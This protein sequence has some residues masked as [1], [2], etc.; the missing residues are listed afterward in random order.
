[1]ETQRPVHRT[2]FVVDVE[3]FGNRDRNNRHQA[4][5][6]D[7]LYRTVEEAFREAEIP[8]DADACEDR[9]DGMFVLIPPEVPKSLFVEALPTAL[10]AGLQAYN[11]TR[12]LQEQI[13]LRMA[14][15]AGEVIYDRHGVTGASINLAFRLVD[16]RPLKDALARS[17][18]ALAIIVSS[19]F[20]EEVVQHLAIDDSV[21]YTPVSVVIKETNTTGW[22]CLPDH[23]FPATAVL[24]TL[25]TVSTPVPQSPYKGLRAFER[26]DRDLFFG[27]AKVVRELVG[28][29]AA[30]ALV[31][32]VGASG[33]GK[34]SVVHAGLL[35]R[36]ED[37][38][39][40]GFVTV[41]PRPTLLTALA[42]GLIQLSGTATPIPGTQ[43]EEWR[44]RISER[45]LAYAAEVA[46]GSSGLERLLIV[47]DQ[48]E[49]VLGQDCDVLLQ[50]LANLP[51]DGTLTVV[52]TL[53]EDSFGD[54]FVRHVS[55]GERLRNNA[56][57]L[58]G[59]DRSEVAEAVRNPA[60]LRDVQITDPL[61]DE[62]AE[63]IL[64]HP[65]ALPLLEFS[66]DQMWRTLRPGDRKLSFD[67]YEEIGRV[68]GAL[69]THADRILASMSEADQA[70]VRKVFVN[71][72][73][74]PVRPGVRKVVLRSECA[75][76]EWQVIVRLA[77]ERLLTIRRDDDGNETGEVVHEALLRAW[78]QLRNWLTT[79]EPFRKW[80]QRLR[81][82]MV[83]WVESRESGGF[84]TGT[85]LADSERWVRERAAD[86]KL[87]ELRFVEMSL[88][89]RKQEQQRYQILYH[90]S[91]ARTLSYASEATEDPVLALL[92]AIEVLE[93]SPDAQ[94]D[95]LVRMC[96]SQLKAAEI[97]PAS[98]EHDRWGRDRFGRRLTLAEWSQVPGPDGRWLLCD[99]STGLSIDRHGRA[100]CRVGSVMA[101]PGPVVVGACTPTGVACLG[102]EQGELALW[103]VADRPEK[104]ISRD[105]GVTVT[106]LAI[107][108]TARTVAV[109]C[110]TDDEEREF[111]LV[112]RGD[113]L[114][115][116]G[117]IPRQ[118]YIWDV[119]MSD[120]RLVAALSYD[121]RILIWDLVAE[122]LVCES[123]SGVGASRLAIY[124]DQDHV[125][126][127]DVGTSSCLGF[128]PLS[129][130][131][132]T[133]WARQAAGRELT[134][135]ER[136][137]YIEDPSL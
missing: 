78:G 92:L 97:A 134:D 31:P 137:R 125:I 28:T 102:T 55:F 116:I 41:R 86:L 36:L 67:A 112:L 64:G 124:P 23:P 51:D 118:G 77:N 47:V 18:G 126:V 95:R 44:G 32:V 82:E 99:S 114:S 9:G 69:T 24:E 33:V 94:A 14:L 85:Q 52:L 17:S 53:R 2:I 66:L 93:R 3:G 113:D 63:A 21:R 62:L 132:L 129:K 91:L 6:R 136:Q 88:K 56:I 58:R 135:A 15:N 11:G 110:D 60:A 128:F 26:A 48:F 29:V 117:R 71:Y 80:R 105:L 127:G 101:M 83:P 84:L 10:V 130:A 1:M 50:Q 107:S 87:D 90:R 45:G 39:G 57:A 115:D 76:S 20:F 16:A 8:W 74:S 119:D 37:E 111:I 34:S 7:G 68:D 121:R 22:V 104:I 131:T 120:D 100:R 30:H 13:R 89:Q 27:R 19:W 25:P 61:I 46:C 103:Q 54:F 43:L 109:A 5:V 96:L 65:G 75:P 79:E 42:V 108:D 133:E 106:C 35:P 98:T 49:E 40:W 38:T 70:V 123:V 4:T 12:V 73:T 122:A 59:M 81:D 72:L